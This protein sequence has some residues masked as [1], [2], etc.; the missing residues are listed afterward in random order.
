MSLT[1]LWNI[2][3]CAA[4]QRL[5]NLPQRFLKR[6]AKPLHPDRRFD[7]MISEP[8]THADPL[9][10]LPEPHPGFSLEGFI[11]SARKQIILKALEAAGGNQ[12]EA[13]RLLGIS[14]QAVSKFL[15]QSDDYNR[16]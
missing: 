12:S 16:S 7:L 4:K 2:K 9:D 13:A 14:P 6:N 11:G 8:V 10:A 3:N 5:S 15:K 1:T